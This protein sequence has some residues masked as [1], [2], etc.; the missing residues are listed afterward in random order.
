MPH[1]GRLSAPRSFASRDA[2]APA[3]RR[4]RRPLVLLLV[5]GAAGAAVAAALSSQSPRPARGRGR[6]GGGASRGDEP[7]RRMVAPAPA[8]RSIRPVPCR[9]RGSRRR[10]VDAVLRSARALCHGRRGR[11]DAAPRRLLLPARVPERPPAGPGPQDGRRVRRLGVRPALGARRAR[12]PVDRIRRAP[13][14][15]PCELPGER[16]PGGERLAGRG[17]C[18]AAGPGDR[19]DAHRARSCGRAGAPVHRRHTAEPAG[20]RL[21]RRRRRAGC[22]R[23]LRALARRS[24]L[25]RRGRS[26]RLAELDVRDPRGPAP[27]RVRRASGPRSDRR[28]VGP[29]G[30]ADEAGPA[31]RTPGDGN[32]TSGLPSA[33][34][35]CGSRTGP[36][37]SRR[38]W[39]PTGARSASRP[40]GA[41]W[42]RIDRAGTPVAAILHDPG[43]E[44]DP[45]LLRAAGTATLLSLDSRHLEDEI[46][47]ARST[48][49]ATAEEERRGLSEISTM[50]RSST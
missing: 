21:G 45:E 26:R 37:P 28:G 32:G 19:S 23:V 44:V 13:R 2:L 33:I 3:I 43:L 49:L 22:G 5:A 14:I 4:L 35:A 6:A 25:L 17:R 15:V 48:I 41:G 7:G 47:A 12:L 46:R 9:P 36:R 42:H 18:A 40:N 1:V 8:G 39:A 30:H 50:G 31:R 27:A 10:C 38:I 11:R 16:A 29:R 34:R 20:G 24:G